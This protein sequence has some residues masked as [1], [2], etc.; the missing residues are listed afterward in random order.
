MKGSRW[1]DNGAWGNRGKGGINEIRFMEKGGGGRRSQLNQ[2]EEKTKDKKAVRKNYSQFSRNEENAW[3]K[4]K[5]GRR[6]TYTNRPA[7]TSKRWAKKKKHVT[8]FSSSWVRNSERPRE[9]E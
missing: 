2:Q 1:S 5:K 9:E 4:K 6:R 3:G 8:L 7:H